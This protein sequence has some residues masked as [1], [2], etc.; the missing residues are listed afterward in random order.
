MNGACMNSPSGSGDPE[1]GATAV[2]EERAEQAALAS[3][4]RVAK[5]VE[6]DRLPL[7]AVDAALQGEWRRAVRLS[8]PY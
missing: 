6:V 1:P 7:A 5:L 2:R 4:I 3:L 8:Q